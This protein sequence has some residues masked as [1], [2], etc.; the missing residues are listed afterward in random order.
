M[1]HGKSK[2]AHPHE[3][4]VRTCTETMTK[5]KD[6]RHLTTPTIYNKLLLEERGERNKQQIKYKQQAEKIKEGQ[7]KVQT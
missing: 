7:N 3:Q 4:Y 1:S 5:I 6:L 2:T